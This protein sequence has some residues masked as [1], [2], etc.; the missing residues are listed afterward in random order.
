MS[1][2]EV[3]AMLDPAY[4]MPRRPAARA[5]AN[6]PSGWVIRGKPVGAKASKRG[7]YA[8]NCRGQLDLGGA[9]QIAGGELEATERRRVA[10]QRHLVLGAPVDVVE[11]PARQPTSSRQ[12]QIGDRV[13]P[14]QPPPLPAALK[15]PG[16]QQRGDLRRPYLEPAPAV[17]AMPHSSV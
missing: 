7:W 9:A 6:S 5:T 17:A 13:A 12:P 11:H 15:H 1:S 14:S 16:P 4:G 3:V 8:E 10:P 2:I